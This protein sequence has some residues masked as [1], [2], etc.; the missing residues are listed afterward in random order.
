MQILSDYLRNLLKLRALLYIGALDRE[1]WQ[2]ALE[3]ELDDERAPGLGLADYLQVPA[4]KRS[5]PS[6]SIHVFGHLVLDRLV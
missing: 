6:H 5:P 3:V 1:L 2:V 4:R